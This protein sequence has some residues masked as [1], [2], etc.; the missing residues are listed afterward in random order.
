MPDRFWVR[1]AGEPAER[2]ATAVDA[3]II[4][5]MCARGDKQHDVAS[6]FGCNSGRIN[7]TKK[8]R[9]FPDAEPASIHPLPP[10]GPY[11]FGGRGAADAQDDDPRKEQ[12]LQKLIEQT[13]TG[14]EKLRLT[15]NNLLKFARELGI[16][17]KPEAPKTSRRHPMGA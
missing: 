6:W 15:Q 5:G 1:P 13:A 16:I 11:T 8:G 9:R 4:K 2:P 3:A 10:P 7:E 14:L 17:E 12:K